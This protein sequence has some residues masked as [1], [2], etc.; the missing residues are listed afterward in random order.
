MLFQLSRMK[1][2]GRPSFF[3]GKSLIELAAQLKN[4]KG[5][6]VSRISFERYPEKSYYILSHVEL[7]YH[8]GVSGDIQISELNT[9][10]LKLLE[11]DRVIN[12][13]EYYWDTVILI[14]EQNKLYCE[15]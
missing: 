2:F 15:S 7:G 12:R 10:I 9:F 6:V 8:K 5:R 4:P 11:F 3:H 14:H 13:I 1:L